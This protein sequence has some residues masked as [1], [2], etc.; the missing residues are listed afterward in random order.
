MG[1]A[2]YVTVGGEISNVKPYKT[3]AKKELVPP[4]GSVGRDRISVIL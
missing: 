4:F 1:D 2:E 3:E